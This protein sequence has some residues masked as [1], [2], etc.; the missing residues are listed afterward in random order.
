LAMDALKAPGSGA[1][2]TSLL[3]LTALAV[4]SA[5]LATFI[6]ESPVQAKH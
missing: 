5:V 3:V 2:T 1:M 4:M 6:S